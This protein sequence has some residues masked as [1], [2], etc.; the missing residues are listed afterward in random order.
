LAIDWLLTIRCF[1]LAG[2]TLHPEPIPSSDRATVHGIIVITAERDDY[3]EIG[4]LFLKRRLPNAT[5]R[6]VFN[7]FAVPTNT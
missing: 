5:A 7:I 1:A 2:T 6:S 3:T 4:Q